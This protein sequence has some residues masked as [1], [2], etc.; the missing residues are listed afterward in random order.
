MRRAIGWLLAVALTATSLA[1]QGAPP[2]T[3]IYLV[4]LR[5]GAT[6]SDPPENLTNRP[7]YDNQPAFTPDGKAI[8]FTSIRADGQADVYRLDLATR[9]ITQLT[10]TPESEYSPTPLPTG[11]GFSVVRVEM[12]STQRLWAFNAQGHSPVLL[13][14]DVAP[15][16]YH[17]WLDDHTLALFVDGNNGSYGHC[18]VGSY[19][20]QEGGSGGIMGVVSPLMAQYAY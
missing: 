20:C 2:G 19:P 4:R 1:A 13:L 5:S 12:D 14:P 10:K 7:G 6:I 17:L 16:G 8:L 9:A 18:I 3:D 11:T 15:V